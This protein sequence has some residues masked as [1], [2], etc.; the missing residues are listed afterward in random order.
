M[1]FYLLL[2]GQT[3]SDITDHNVLGETSSFNKPI[4]TTGLAWAVLHRLINHQRVE[5]LEKITIKD[6][7]N[8]TYTI[9][10]FLTKLQSYNIV[11][12]Y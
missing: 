4:F 7:S 1:I 3:E 10:N 2:P 6:S 11:T 9:D 8:N 12:G 5:V